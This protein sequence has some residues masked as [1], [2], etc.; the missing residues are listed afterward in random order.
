MQ[1]LKISLKA[2]RV[3]ADLTQEEAASQLGVTRQTVINWES[4]KSVPTQCTLKVMSNV[5]DVPLEMLEVRKE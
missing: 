3:N 2:A 5:Y 4:G 1:R